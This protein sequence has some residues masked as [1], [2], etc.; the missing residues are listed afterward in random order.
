MA[1]TF[2]AGHRIKSSL[3]P[4][5]KKGVGKKDRMTPTTLSARQ[6]QRLLQRKKRGAGQARGV[7][8][9]FPWNAAC[10]AVLLKQLPGKPNDP[11]IKHLRAAWKIVHAAE[12]P[13]L[14]GEADRRC[15]CAVCVPRV[16]PPLL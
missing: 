9:K 15:G 6:S 16:G 11:A 8:I 7:K 2:G 4:A 14:A 3:G 1:K 5:V 12:W 13:Q 10:R